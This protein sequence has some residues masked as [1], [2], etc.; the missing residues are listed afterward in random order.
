MKINT[1]SI[2]AGTAACNASCPY[3]ISKMTGI[4]EVGFKEPEINWKNFNK[5][6]RL[7]Q[8]NN[9]STVLITGKGEPTLYPEQITKFLKNIGKYD[10]PLIELQT[11]GL[12]LAKKE[13]DK[14]LKEW[15]NL[16]LNTIAISIVHYKRE[17]NGKIF[18]PNR[19]YPEL[20]K[21]IDKLH[22]IG[23]SI[24]LSCLLMKEFID[25][26]EEIKDLV[27]FAKSNKV[28]QVT[29]RKL[30]VEKDSENS[31]IKAWCEKHAMKSSDITKIKN[32]LDKNAKRLMVL[33]HGAIVYELEKQ[34]LCLTDCV[35][36]RPNT[37]E[38]RT[39][40]FFP[41]GHLRYNWEYGGAI[42]L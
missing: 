39:L 28:E 37:D 21:L 6:C 11:N 29:L 13:Y 41:D 32:H 23:Y 16:G 3:C 36:V 38:I 10:F 8:V 34:N 30:G 26:P 9:V 17:E 40:I 42:L 33:P 4:E 7:A 27:E 20:E 15:L 5:A 1:F 14:Y 24:R 31:E 18:T 22:K 25:T 2:I 35:M 12:T 19:E